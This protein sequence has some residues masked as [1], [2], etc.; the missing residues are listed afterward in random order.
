MRLEVLTAVKK[1]VDVQFLGSNTIW[2][3]VGRYQDFGGTY[4]ATSGL[5][6]ISTLRITKVS[7]YGHVCLQGK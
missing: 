6:Y 7:M 5:K 1:L 3:F 4:A 2:T